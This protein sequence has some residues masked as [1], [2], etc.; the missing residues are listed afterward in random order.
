MRLIAPAVP[1]AAAVFLVCGGPLRA[2]EPP[3][4]KEPA[5]DTSADEP[6][7]EEMLT[8]IE[9]ARSG[10]RAAPTEAGPASVAKPRRTVIVAEVPPDVEE[11]AARILAQEVVLL[12]EGN[13]V[14][15]RALAEDA[16]GRA[17]LKAHAVAFRAA[18][19]VAG[20]LE[21]RVA[22]VRAAAGELVG[23]KVFVRATKGMRRGELEKVT[24]EGLELALKIVINRE[25][26]RIDRF[27]VAWKDLTPGQVDSF[28]KGWTP[29]SADGHMAKAFIAITGGD[30][31]AAG[32]ALVA[33]GDHPLAG[34]L[35]ERVAAMAVAASPSSA[36]GSRAVGGEDRRRAWPPSR[37]VVQGLFK[38]KLRGY[39]P[40]TLRVEL[41]YDFEDPDELRDFRRIREPRG[42]RHPF[43]HRDGA[44]HPARYGTYM[45]LEGVFTSAIASVEFRRVGESRPEAGLIGCAT[46][47]GKG[48]CFFVGSRAGREMHITKDYG[49]EARQT[50]GAK[51][52]PL[53]GQ[54]AGTIVLKFERGQVAGQAGTAI[55]EAA[56]RAYSSGRVGLMANRASLDNLKVTGTLAPEWLKALIAVREM[57]A[58]HEAYE[59]GGHWYWSYPSNMSWHEARDS[60][61]VVGGHLVSITSAAENAIAGWVAGMRLR[62]GEG[63]IGLTDERREGAWAWVSGER[64]GFTAWHENQP[65]EDE[66]GGNDY[67]VFYAGAQWRAR[68]TTRRVGFVCEWDPARKAEV[69][70]A[71]AAAAGGGDERT[72]LLGT[73]YGAA[74]FSKPVL[75]RLD[76]KIDFAWGQGAPAP[77]VPVTD[78]FSVRWEGSIEPVESANYVLSVRADD[79]VALWIGG[80]KIIDALVPGSGTRR[81]EPVPL[82]RGKRYPLRLDYM[83]RTQTA[84]VQ[85]Q[86]APATAKRGVVVPSRCLRPPK[87]YERMPGPPI[88]HRLLADAI[89]KKAERVPAGKKGTGLSGTYFAGVN[90]EKMVTRRLDG[91]ISFT[92]TREPAPGVPTDKFSVRW[93]GFVAPPRSGTYTFITS[94]DDGVRLALAGVVVL[95]VWSTGA[96]PRLVSA[97]V[98]LEAGMMYPVRLDFYDTTGPAHV[99]LMWRGPGF[100]D[101]LVSASCL[102]PSAGPPS[103]RRGRGEYR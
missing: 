99:R 24:D 50:L 1:M 34:L 48:Y 73:Y 29:V 38:G 87:N 68:S 46:Y 54:D 26:R 52:S 11:R 3:P 27:T 82:E 20:E 39:S 70:A 94:G 25:V 5:T 14:A 8:V 40:A 4:H 74:D 72:G 62:Y 66:S 59:F 53:A 95:D 19:A 103:L 69:D 100:I 56:D 83:E 75:R 22:V 71:R 78:N 76:A 2:A 58:P 42:Q 28:A 7:I 13:H 65:A 64:T 37:E 57:G 60:C 6:S 15:A 30:A 23:K 12:E 97:A 47:D 41:L 31:K 81:S 61:A 93:R 51:P 35:R 21:K 80:R 36:T 79:G 88:F 10:G 84:D 32:D 96:K 45:L 86:W 90:H 18:A 102:F 77:G 16:A 98:E 55:V 43:E 63:W 101:E 89:R 9:A 49:T 91:P 33:A 92:W 85:L 67:A 17:E 44:L